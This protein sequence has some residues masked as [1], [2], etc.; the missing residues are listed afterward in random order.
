MPQ[1]TDLMGLGMSHQLAGK[2]GNNVATVTAQGATFASATSI[3]PD[4]KVAA[5]TASNSGNFVALATVGIR[6]LLGDEIKIMNLLSA[7][8]VVTAPSAITFYGGGVSTAGT[9]GVSVATGTYTIFIP[10]TAS[11]VILK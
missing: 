6:Q 5:I 4:V 2:V 9:T 11:T 10:V 3:G 7:S 1:A 8:I